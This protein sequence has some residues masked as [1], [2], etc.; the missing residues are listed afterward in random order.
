MEL[1]AFEV[2]KDGLLDL[3]QVLIMITAVTFGG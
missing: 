3:N 1:G 2:G